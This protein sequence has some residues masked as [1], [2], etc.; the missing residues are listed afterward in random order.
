MSSKKEVL[1]K[2]FQDDSSA[3][4]DAD[5]DEDE[6]SFDA[7]MRRQILDKRK[8]LGD[9]PPKSKSKPNPK[10]PDGIKSSLFVQFVFLLL[11]LGGK[12]FID[13]GK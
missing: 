2:E 9:I 13:H 11:I 10:L 4:S 1:Q 7:R 6:A 8:E 5:D 12:C 3:K